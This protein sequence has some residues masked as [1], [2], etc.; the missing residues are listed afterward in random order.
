MLKYEKII[1]MEINKPFY[2][3]ITAK[4]HDSARYL[5]FNIIDGGVPFSL[6]GRTVRVWGVKP[7]GDKVYNDL[8][9]IDGAKGIAELQLTTQMLAVAGILQLE[10]EIKEGTT[11]LST[12]PFAVIIVPSL[13]DAN[14]V[15]ST[16][17]FSVLSKAIAIVDAVNARVSSLEAGKAS[18][19]YVDTKI[20]SIGATRVFKGTNTNA[21]ILAL[22]GMMAGDEWYDTTNSTYLAFTGTAWVDIGNNQ[23]TQEIENLCGIKLLTPAVTSDFYIDSVGAIIGFAAFQY[24]EKIQ[25][26]KGDRISFTAKGLYGTVSVLSVYN[27]VKAY[28]KSPY[29]G[30]STPTSGSYECTSDIEYVVLCGV[31]SSAFTIKKYTL[32]KIDTSQERQAIEDLCGIKSLAPAIT[33]GSYVGAT[34][35]SINPLTGYQYTEMI[36][37]LKG[38]R[39]GFTAKGVYSTV[40][41]LSIYTV[42]KA[43]LKTVAT[44]TSTVASG[45]YECTSDVE[46]AI[47]SGLQSSPFI[48]KKYTFVKTD[49]SKQT[50][51]IE[52]LCNIQ[53]LAPAVTTG[54]YIAT[55]GSVNAFAA[56]QYTEKIQLLKGDKISF[57]AKGAYNTVAVLSVYDITKTFVRTEVIGS[58]TVYSGYYECVSDVEYVVLCGTQSS[59]FSIKKHTAGGADSRANL[60]YDSMGYAANFSLAFTA[61][62]YITT[63]GS[64]SPVGNFSVSELFTL[65][66]GETLVLSAKGY[67]SNVAV[68]YR[69]DKLGNPLRLI[70]VGT[71]VIAKYT[72]TATNTVEYLKICTG[73]VSSLYY[74]KYTGVTSVQ[75]SLKLVDE[76]NKYSYYA[77]L[78]SKVVCVGDSL[79]EGNFGDPVGIVPSRSYPSY[80]ARFANWSVTNVGNGGATAT[81]YWNTQMARCTYA[82]K[83]CVILCLGTNAGLTDTLVADTTITDGQ[84]Y[85]NYATT[86]TG[87]YCK[88]IE[89]IKSQNPKIKIFLVGILASPSTTNSVISQI[90]TKYDLPYLDVRNNGYIDLSPSVVMHPS[91]DTVHFGNIGYLSLAKSI[92]TMVCKAIA[93]NPEK[94]ELTY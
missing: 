1:N 72:Y 94:Y 82:D 48:V 69:Y 75:N 36:Q 79:T 28:V 46:Y 9:I 70:S 88:I 53:L 80:I 13:Q 84:T 78:F 60:V 2:Q 33:L 14:A 26:L 31:K 61:G 73:A 76:F 56:F 23:D 93:S 85:L 52:T 20:S 21:A 59:T 25:L 71:D 66:Q 22:T 4:R 5:L 77:Y 42:D 45:Y 89:Y 91:S 44:G 51:E 6:V 17:E 37:L 10:L 32:V 34:N 43:F 41:V 15:E 81:T 57:T 50:Q 29:L 62:Y 49:T 19:G 30:S 16:N 3:P 92:F 87:S 83:D 12:I 55:S 8:S 39:I 24:T 40:A 86:N 38:D 64:L 90:A 27:D 47:V 65:N 67:L 7:D 74:Y 18:L 11:S 54:S 68:I 63:Y 58:S 35:G